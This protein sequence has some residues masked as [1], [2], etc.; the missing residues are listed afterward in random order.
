MIGWYSLK[1]L[2]YFLAENHL[3]ESRCLLENLLIVWLNEDSTF[4]GRKSGFKL[5]KFII[6]NIIDSIE[7]EVL[8]GLLDCSVDIFGLLLLE[9]L[10][11]TFL[12]VGC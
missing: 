9:S 1:E 5:D 3:V 4:Y 6:G 10:C 11:L 8:K 7:L 12:G 2:T